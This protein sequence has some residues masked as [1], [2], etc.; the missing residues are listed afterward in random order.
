[1][2]NN[3]DFY[4][5]PRTKKSITNINASLIINK[6]N[7][8][9]NS[10]IKKESEINQSSNFRTMYKHQTISLENWLLDDQHKF[11]SAK[12]PKKYIKHTRNLKGS[13]LK[14]NLRKS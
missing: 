12:N 6:L 2:S 13:I 1:M 7:N 14:F 10:Y 11:Y 4:I 5:T 9:K 8:S 3:G